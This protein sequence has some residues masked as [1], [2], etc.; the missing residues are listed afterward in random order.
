MIQKNRINQC[1]VCGEAFDK[2]ETLRGH[3]RRVHVIEAKVTLGECELFFI[4]LVLLN[5]LLSVRD[6]DGN[7]F[8]P[9]WRSMCCRFFYV[10][11]G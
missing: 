8:R 6:T 10:P 11:L 2:P 3:R 7:I 9:P 1:A 4:F 5:V